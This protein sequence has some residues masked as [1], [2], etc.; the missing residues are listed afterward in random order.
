MTSTGLKQLMC[1]H[2][3]RDLIW[4]GRPL[5]ID[6]DR[7]LYLTMNVASLYA[8]F[9]QILALSGHEGSILRGPISYDF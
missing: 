3:C 5:A 2:T 1:M 6:R 8:L 7:D 4:T 9:I